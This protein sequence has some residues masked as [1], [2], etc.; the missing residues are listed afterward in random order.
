MSRVVAG[1]LLLPNGQPMANASIYFTAKRTEAV[2][3]VEG[4]NTFF[5]T[6]A[7]GVYNQSVVNGWYAVSIEYI[8]DAS[9]SHTR[10]W[11]LGDVF[12]E[13]GAASTL[14]A[15][16]IA[17]NAPDDLALGIFY[18]I[19]EEAQAAAESAQASA[20]A[21][22]NSAASITPTTSPTDTTPGRL[23]RTNDLVKTVSKDDV[24]IGRMVKAGDA[25]I[26]GDTMDVPSPPGMNSWVAGGAWRT[27]SADPNALGASSGYLFHV[28]R[29]ASYAGQI[30]LYENGRA[31]FRTKNPS[32]WTANREFYSTGNTSSFV[33][34]LLNATSISAMHSALEINEVGTFTPVVAGVTTAGVGT[35]TA[36]QGNYVRSGKIVTCVINLAWSAHTGAGDMIVTGLPFTS[37]TGR[38]SIVSPYYSGITVAAGREVR[39]Q[40]TGLS[41]GIYM[42]S[43]DPAGG[44]SLAIPIDSVVP[45][46]RMTFTYMIN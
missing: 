4:A 44:S 36:Q 35:Y 5:N 43:C 27:L 26:L 18:Q 16:I 31:S 45:A 21:A 23:W 15:L 17:S 3:I 20:A 2:S 33:Q 19:L 10:R 46:L 25:G 41:A 14:E 12:I 22:A 34:S 29:G 6:N 8:A 40:I 32:G 1:T 38:F 11:P 42:R 30:A 24:V 7:A 37:L 9:S 28:N 39:G 13:D